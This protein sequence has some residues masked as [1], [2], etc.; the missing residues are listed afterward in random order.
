MLPPWATLRAAC[1]SWESYVVDIPLGP[2]IGLISQVIKLVK[3]DPVLRAIRGLEGQ[4]ADIEEGITRQLASPLLAGE[5]AL[6][7]AT[8]TPSARARTRLLNE[9]IEYFRNAYH[10]ANG[11]AAA[12]CAE[13][14]SCTYGLTGEVGNAK[15]WLVRA[16]DTAVDVHDA[17]LD[18][19][20]KP[21]GD[22]VKDAVFDL[23]VLDIKTVVDSE[24][25]ISEFVQRH[26]D[27]DLMIKYYYGPSA[28]RVERRRNF[29]RED[30]L[31]F[32]NEGNI[33]SPKE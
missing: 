32:D 29:F 26:P 28:Q 9:A 8:S 22:I 10:L 31:V 2:A 6:A 16:R 24:R 17:A 12:R 21:M 14:V 13:Y 19:V 23:R 30:V 27:I 7:D 1:R 18:R 3:G 11:V 20:L 4:L 25:W 15:S 5:S 33:V